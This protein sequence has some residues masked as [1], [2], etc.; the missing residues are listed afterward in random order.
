MYSNLIGKLL[1]FSII[2][3]ERQAESYTPFQGINKLSNN[4]M[5][6]YNKLKIAYCNNKLL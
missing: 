2:T 6:L 3:A 5:A 4:N 1:L